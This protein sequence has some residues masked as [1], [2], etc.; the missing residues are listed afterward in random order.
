MD[1]G[2]DCI[3]TGTTEYQV[4]ARTTCIVK[5]FA[6][7]DATFSALNKYSSGS[8]NFAS[9]FI[10]NT[11]KLNSNW[12][13]NTTL[14]GQGDT[15]KTYT[16]STAPIPL[17]IKATDY[18][19]DLLIAFDSLSGAGAGPLT[20]TGAYTFGRSDRTNDD[21]LGNTNT[22]KF[23]IENRSDASAYFKLKAADVSSG[24]LNSLTYSNISDLSSMSDVGVMNVGGDARVTTNF[25]WQKTPDCILDARGYRIYPRK[26]CYV[27]FYGRSDDELSRKNNYTSNNV[28]Y[29]NFYVENTEGPYSSWLNPSI[30]GVFTNS[31]T[32]ASLR[33]GGLDSYLLD[34]RIMYGSGSQASPTKHDFG[35]SAKAGTNFYGQDTTLIYH[36]V[37][38]R[39]GPAY[40]KIKLAD[41]FSG[42]IYGTGAKTWSGLTYTN[43]LTSYTDTGV[44][45]IG[46]EYI[47]GGER[48]ASNLYYEKSSDCQVDA[49]GYKIAG[50]K[51]CTITFHGRSDPSLASFTGT[52]VP[53]AKWFIEN[54]HPV[55]SKWLTNSGSNDE[56]TNSSIPVTLKMKSSGYVMPNLVAT[57]ASSSKQSGE[58]TND[59]GADNFGTSTRNEASP[60]ILPGDN[61]YW[62]SLTYT[63]NNVGN[64]E[65]Y[66]K[67]Q[68]GGGDSS[69]LLRTLAYRDPQNIF[70]TPSTS[71]T[72]VTTAFNGSNVINIGSDSR[73]NFYWANGDAS[74]L[75]GCE[76]NSRGYKMQPNATC[77]VTFY[78]RGDISVPGNSTNIMQFLLDPTQRVVSNDVWTMP[79]RKVTGKTY[80]FMFPLQNY[81][82]SE[83]MGYIKLNLEVTGTMIE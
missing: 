77:S 80:G 82:F 42:T 23:K 2:T 27:T 29:V 64:I 6:R 16:T 47:L 72:D 5:F 52:S 51:T 74:G 25:Y 53:I 28:P 39:N 13:N 14:N 10:E 12:E 71:Q 59:A 22:L 57:Y 34:L 60:T 50:N 66:F 26:S 32:P 79:I 30:N 61:A 58:P 81:I 48:W 46:G 68:L 18:Q 55:Y 7:T 31:G 3:D 9:F 33:M 49:L 4:K 76:I 41:A 35:T 62:K 17:P 43:A 1:L 56:Y 70:I 24:S 45:D 19:I 78:Y 73:N 65:T 69:R 36:L 8:L 15:N 67:L 44:M 40:F 21:I 83:S 54:T 20:T 63:I 11:D 37:N 75:N 38:S